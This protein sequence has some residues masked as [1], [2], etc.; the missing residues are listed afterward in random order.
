M[1][2]FFLAMLTGTMLTG[3][4]V[5][6]TNVSYLFLLLPR[7]FPFMF[8]DDLCFLIQDIFRIRLIISVK[9]FGAGIGAM[10]SGVDTLCEVVFKSEITNNSTIGG[11]WGLTNL[12]TPKG[13]S[14]P[15]QQLTG[16]RNNWWWVAVPYYQSNKNLTWFTLLV[17]SNLLFLVELE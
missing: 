10:G 3:L 16:G 1:I 11:V 6:A 5:S 7:I 15:L 13:Q 8:G 4:P 14:T 17:L 9:E 12:T 2:P